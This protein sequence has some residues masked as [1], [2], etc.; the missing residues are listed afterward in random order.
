MTRGRQVNIDEYISEIKEYLLFGCS[1]HEACMS[2]KIP[3]NTVWDYY[4]QDEEVR[5]KIDAYKANSLTTA[6][7]TLFAGLES[8]PKLAFD[9]L[10]NKCP[11]EFS[12][13]TTQD[14]NATVDLN[15]RLA[16]LE[17]P[18]EEELNNL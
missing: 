18:T 9:Y 17:E 8:D 1:L 12:T 2:A 4:K 15:D 3:Y 13:K 6:R 16:E 11:D 5:E 10:R 7:K 14:I